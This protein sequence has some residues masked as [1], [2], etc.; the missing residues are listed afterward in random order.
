MN[1]DIGGGKGDKKGWI[2]MDIRDDSNIQWDLNEFPWPLKD[3]SV[4][5]VRMNHVLEHLENPLRVMKEIYRICQH[6]STVR[7]E[8]PWWQDDLYSNPAH[9][10]VF[11]PEWFENLNSESI[12]WEGEMQAPFNFIVLERDWIRGSRRFWKIYEYHVELMVVK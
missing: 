9:L 7:I 8:I 4:E 3:D 12:V 10:H 1:L 5:K 11:K 6:Y 2:T